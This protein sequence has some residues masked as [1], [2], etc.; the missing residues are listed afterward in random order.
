MYHSLIVFSP[1]IPCSF[2]SHSLSLLLRMYCHSFNCHLYLQLPLN[3]A[4]IYNTNYFF[5]RG[6]TVVPH[7]QGFT[8][9]LRHTTV[10]RAPLDEWSARRRGI[11]LWTH[12]THKRQ[13]SMP[14]EGLEP[15]VFQHATSRWGTPL[16]ARPLV[17]ATR[18]PSRVTLQ[19]HRLT[20]LFRFLDS[21]LGKKL[22]PDF[23]ALFVLSTPA[24]YSS[25]IQTIA[26]VAHSTTCIFGFGV[27]P[28]RRTMTPWRFGKRCCCCLKDE[29][30]TVLDRHLCTLLTHLCKDHTDNT[31]INSPLRWK[32]QHLCKRHSLPRSK[33]TD[34]PVRRVS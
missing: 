34:D 31:Q 5:L 26:A 29:L 27:S 3:Y 7:F 17:S 4:P 32:L 33:T 15:E 22:S 9:T 8:I 25:N 19:K 24:S 2:S 10:G 6:A 13:T 14:P 18:W 28:R 12:N 11:Y 23:S 1:D 20:C 16:A 21:L 30:L